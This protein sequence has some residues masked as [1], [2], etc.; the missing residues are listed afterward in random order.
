MTVISHQPWMIQTARQHMY[1]DLVDDKNLFRTRYDLFVLSLVY[2]LLHNK[3]C[4][5]RPHADMVKV[6]SIGSESTKHIIDVAYIL[7]DDGKDERDIKAQLLRIADGGVEALSDIYYKTN[8][9]DIHALIA[10]AK[11]IWPVRM[12]R[13]A[14][15]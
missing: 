13:F 8:N 7:L 5:D 6:N 3:A 2:G 9:L 10:E 14:N 11:L 12:K 4:A 1:D 15:I